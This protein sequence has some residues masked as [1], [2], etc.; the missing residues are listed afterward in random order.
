MEE[1]PM[2]AYWEKEYILLKGFPICIWRL[3]K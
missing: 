3:K 1:M 2:N